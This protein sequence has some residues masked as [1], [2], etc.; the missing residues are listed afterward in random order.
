MGSPQ[1]IASL[2]EGRV[3]TLTTDR[4]SADEIRSRF[5]I[6]DMRALADDR[7]ELRIAGDCDLPGAVSVP[8]RL[9]DAYMLVLHEAPVVGR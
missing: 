9:E 3:W 4:E 7:I 5:L 2:A 6:V 1:R 8:P